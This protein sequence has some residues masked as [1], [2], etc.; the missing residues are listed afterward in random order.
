V[1]TERETIECFQNNEAATCAY[2]RRKAAGHSMV[3]ALR[4]ALTTLTD[5]R[6]HLCSA[7]MALAAGALFV[8]LSG[9]GHLGASYV[10]AAPLQNRGVVYV[11]RPSR[12]K[13]SA[14]NVRLLVADGQQVQAGGS[15]SI[16]LIENGGYVPVAAL[17]KTRITYPYVQKTLDL[18]VLPGNSYYVRVV[19]NGGL[20]FQQSGGL[21]L[22]DEATGRTEIASTNIQ[23]NTYRGK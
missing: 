2:Q 19:L 14:I 23:E 3:T 11:Y 18:D 15:T 9:C 17:G 16:G 8:S 7:L 10:P 6:G 22:V 5:I 12:F 4:S 13:G 1:K 21:E 20:T